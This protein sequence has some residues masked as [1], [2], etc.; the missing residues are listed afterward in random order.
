[1]TKVI[2]TTSWDDGHK[3]DLRTAKLLQKYGFKSTFY[4]SLEDREL[5]QE[6]RL[7][8]NEIRLLAQDFE[9]GAHTMTHPKLDQISDDLAKK[10][11]Y[12]SKYALERITGKPV[13]SFCYPYGSY[14]G[15]IKQF[16]EQAGFTYARSIK[17]FT[18]NSIDR[19]AANT[20]VDT[21]DHMRDGIHSVYN[22]CSKKPWRI[23]KLRRWDNLA[24]ELFFKAQKEDGVFHLWGHSKDIEIHNDWGRLENLLA[25]IAKQ[26]GVIFATNS[27]LPIKKPKLLVA[28]P[29]FR[30][31]LGGLEK[32]A[33]QITSGLKNNFGWE[34]A[35]VTSG[36][37]GQNKVIVDYYEGI[38]VY[39]LPY[40]VK[41]SNTPIGLLWYSE[42]KKIIDIEKPDIIKT[43]MPVPGIADIISYASG[44][45]PLIVTY[46]M[47]SMKKGKQPVDFIIWLYENI[48][49]RRTLAKAQSII[50]PSVFVQSDFLKNYFY[51]T[52]VISP[53]VDTDLFHP[54]Q[55]E[56]KYNLMHVG[57]LKKGEG[58]K[59]L[60]ESLK[61]VAELKNQYPEIHLNIVGR[62]DNYEHFKK[63][64]RKMEIENNVTF[65]GLLK[66][67]DIVTIYQKTNV[68]IAPAKKES[69]GI[70][71]IEAMACGLPVIANNAEGI[72]YLIQNEKNGYIVDVK[73]N[74][75]ADKVKFLFQ[76]PSVAKRIGDA[77]RDFVVAN[78]QWDNNVA[79]TNR[80]LLKTLGLVENKPKL[81]IVTPYFFPK[82]GGLENYAYN[83]ARRLHESGNYEVSVVTSNHKTKKYERE[84][85][86]GMKIYR[87][88][89][90]FKFSNTPVNPLWYWQIKH[91]F[92]R[93][94]PNIIHLHA[95]VPFI[96]DTAALAAGKT[97]KVLTYHAGSMIKGKWPD[98]VLIYIYERIFLPILFRHVNVIVSV[99]KSFGQSKIGKLFA[100]KTKLIMP[101][102][103]TK[104]FTFSSLP[105]NSKIV[106]FVGRVELSS[107]WKGIE[108]L[109]QAISFVIN[110]IPDIKLEIIGGGD[111]IEYYQKQAEALGIKKS[112]KFF[113][114][115][116]GQD[117]IDA[118]QRSSVVVLPSTSEAESFG[119]VL[120]EA[121]ASGR[122]VIG[123]DIGGIAYVIDNQKNGLLVPPKN[124]EA[125]AKAINLI[126]GNKELAKKYADNG[127]IK[128]KN[129]DWEKI[130][131]KTEIIFQ[132]VINENKI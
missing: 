34:V 98:D 81:M 8:E 49:L 26:D 12:E 106:T 53:G 2:V 77:A 44:D 108:Y 92:K 118:Y 74:Q 22:L 32:Y 82:V 115:Q 24:K 103:D 13:T 41:L 37:T 131:N 52:F 114:Y 78:Y 28:A 129:F 112:V 29:Y 83:I 65:C 18:T 70:A 4:I 50:C 6:D 69:F 23:F 20:S 99:S 56:S 73:K 68:F 31:E 25:F 105:S 17:R 36:E 15:K 35:V 104:Q 89:T 76:N 7:D 107:K 84:I 5:R 119:M 9:I 16:V 90:W 79:E 121:M 21:F 33:F 100:Y 46:H 72:P 123:S 88:P 86:A 63:L 10:E 60:I 57:G 109:L 42:I 124:P 91:I 58:H 64:C 39:R 95:P 120:I 55:N 30:Q 132:K 14:N 97:P 27:E 62:G 11:I 126:L 1:M 71:I 94:R 111:A 87:L 3:L 122:P 93:E 130:T 110:D 75:I 117:L 113:G 128:A 66:T 61:A 51:K 38:K 127:T 85:I 102:V 47:G 40:T 67:K 125:L 48:L 59:G 43:H 45:I 54:V 101:G 116:T 19:F 96:S 80:Y